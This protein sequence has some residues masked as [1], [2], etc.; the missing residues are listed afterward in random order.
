MKLVVI[1]PL[2]ESENAYL[3]N[4]YTFYNSLN[5]LTSDILRENSRK[6]I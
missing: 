3:P 2:L 4:I 6:I 1:I 5:F